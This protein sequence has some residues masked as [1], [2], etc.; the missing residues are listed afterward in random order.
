[1][2]LYHCESLTPGVLR[3]KISTRSSKKIEKEN[4]S[5]ILI[6]ILGWS[7]QRLS[8]L[9]E[10]ISRYVYLRGAKS[11][12]G[13]AK[14]PNVRNQLIKPVIYSLWMIWTRV[15]QWRN[16]KKDYDTLERSFTERAITVSFK[17]VTPPFAFPACVCLFVLYLFLQWN[18]PRLH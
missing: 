1:M 9:E 6:E 5:E 10:S 11:I 15:F 12:Y 14:E 13:Q 16:W 3:V 17:K 7:E 18:P 2:G 8:L 4:I